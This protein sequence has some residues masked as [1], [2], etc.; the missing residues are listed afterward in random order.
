MKRTYKRLKTDMELFGAALVQAHVY[1]VSVDEELRV[2]FEDY[3]GIVE[4]I[5]RESVKIS[6]KIFMRDQLEFRVDLVAGE[7]PR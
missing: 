5:K 4:E 2:T 3:G 6:G 7:E 1:V